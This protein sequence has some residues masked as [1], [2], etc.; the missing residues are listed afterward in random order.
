MK[1]AKERKMIF[2]FLFVTVQMAIPLY[3]YTLQEDKLDERF[4]WRMFSI[5]SSELKAITFEGLIGDEA[6]MFDRNVLFGI[7]WNV[8]INKGYPNVVANARKFL[9]D[10]HPYF[11]KVRSTLLY[12]KW[13]GGIEKRIG[14][15]RCGLW[16]DNHIAAYDIATK[17]SHI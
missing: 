6:I 3:Y 14:I 8:I 4:T 2:L 1:G 9:C 12:H 13:E 10:S 11:S 16:K 5:V 17:K 15:T 7:Q